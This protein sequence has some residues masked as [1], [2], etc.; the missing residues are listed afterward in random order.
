MDIQWVDIKDRLPKKNESPKKHKYYL[1]GKLLEKTEKYDFYLIICK[2]MRFVA[3]W[4]DGFWNPCIDSF[5]GEKW[6]KKERNLVLFG[7]FEK[8]RAWA[9][10]NTT[11]WSELS[12]ENWED[13][14][15][16]CKDNPE[17][18]NSEP[19]IISKAT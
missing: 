14:V 8:I 12:Y 13:L 6:N 9:N 7:G 2:S 11:H 18:P 15:K 5:D 4:E 10:K 16:W 3:S 1:N 19:S 17:Y